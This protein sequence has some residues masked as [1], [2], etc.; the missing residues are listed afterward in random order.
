MK[1]E[2][3]RKE[4]EQIRLTKESK[5]ALIHALQAKQVPQA[6][7]KPRRWNRVTLIAAAMA[8]VL[9]ISAGAA[10]VASP[11]VRSYFGNSIGYQQSAVELGES[12]T[13]NGWTMTLTDCA[14]DDYTVYVGVTLTAPEGTVL[15]NEKGYL[16]EDWFPP[17]FP[18]LDVA[19]SGGYMQVEDEDPTDN[20]ISFIFTT[21][22]YYNAG[23]QPLNGQ[24]MELTLGKLYHN[25][26]WDE[27][28]E[29]WLRTY[30]CEEDWTFRTTLNYSDHIT[31]LEPNLPVHTLDVDAT[32]TEVVVSPLT[33]YVQIEGDALK[34]HHDW[35]SKNA[36]DGWYGCV[37]YQEVTLY[38]KDGTAIP[39]M[40]GMSGSGCSGG[41]DRTEDGWI[42]LVRRPETL[43]DVEN[44]AAISICGV[45][46]E[47]SC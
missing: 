27:K 33:V 41:T 34:G 1:Y 13:Q 31:R 15:D 10:V 47:L 14:A 3:Y 38:T 4:L 40:G 12:I 46:I 6:S 42:R 35:V 29:R 30:D 21:N 20:Q 19:G 22:L 17:D 24:L 16:F 23:N 28:E 43:L 45:W 9:V 44:L 25:T 26:V 32:I 11:V 2:Q 8:A 18:E 5:E 36:P 7:R 39:M 37:E